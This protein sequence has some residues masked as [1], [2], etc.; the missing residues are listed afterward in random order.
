MSES[1]YASREQLLDPE[2]SRG[3]A[4]RIA[5]AASLVVH[6]SLVALIVARQADRTLPT[7]SPPKQ[8]MVVSISNSNPQRKQQPAAEAPQIAPVEIDPVLAEDEPVESASPADP[9]A[10]EQGSQAEPPLTAQD[11]PETAF[12]V[13][14]SIGLP[15][16]AGA[17]E[18]NTE[19]VKNSVATYVA[20]YKSTLTSDW[21][22][23]CLRYQN[24]H[25][26]KSCPPGAAGA[27][28]DTT[29]VAAATRQMFSTYVSGAASNARLS[30]QL[31]SEMDTMRPYLDDDS[32]MGELARQRYELAQG[33]YCAMNGGCRGASLTTSGSFATAVSNEGRLRILGIS[34]GGVSLFSGLMSLTFRDGL[35]FGNAGAPVKVV[36]PYRITAT[37][38]DESG[39]E[40]EFKVEAPLFPVRK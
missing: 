13:P 6:L 28:E 20:T 4:L 23:E 36:V 2:E 38:V 17:P 25:G 33:S 8:E 10:A 27:S 31:I 1:L 7:I 35:K 12:D 39:S 18:L 3:S 14:L 19:S 9:T 21:L 29:T 16:N 22:A 15:E 26:V 37:P 34:P 40:E 30:K 11:I 24:E 32:V 5:L